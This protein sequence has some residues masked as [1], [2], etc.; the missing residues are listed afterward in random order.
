MQGDDQLSASIPGRRE[1]KLVHTPP[2]AGRPA[3]CACQR[4]LSPAIGRPGCK[5]QL[6]PAAVCVRNL[7][8]LQRDTFYERLINDAR[9]LLK[10]ADATG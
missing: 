7:W 3:L 2:A 9:I 6:L 5:D 8:C 10:Q 1:Q 4:A